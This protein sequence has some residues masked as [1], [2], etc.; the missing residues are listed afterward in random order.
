MMC[1]RIGSSTMKKPRVNDFIPTTA[2]PLG[3]PID[4]YPRIEKPTSGMQ[5]AAKQAVS[6]PVL[7]LKTS[8]DEIPP[9]TPPPP[10]GAAQTGPEP[11]TVTER[12]DVGLPANL[13]TGKPVN[14]QASL[15]TNQQGSKPAYPQARKPASLQTSKQVKKFS[16]YLLEPSIRALKRLALDEDK[17]DYEVLQEALD[18]YLRQKGYGTSASASKPANG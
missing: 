8:F 17:K 1:L 11:V 2:P 9:N 3:S 13:Q 7:P 6:A 15:P 14:L 10:I 16:S 5:P 18:E 4:D 12:Q